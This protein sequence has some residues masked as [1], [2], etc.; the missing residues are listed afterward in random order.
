MRAP[1][2]WFFQGFFGSV[3]AYTIPLWIAYS[4]FNVTDVG[5]CYVLIGVQ[6]IISILAAIVQIHRYG[7]AFKWVVY[8]LLSTGLNAALLYMLVWAFSVQTAIIA[9]VVAGAAHAGKAC[10]EYERYSRF[11]ESLKS[12]SYKVSEGA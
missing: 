4:Y 7:N 2:K 8:A 9:Y 1:V 10:I 5:L 6:A 11:I 3:A 12:V